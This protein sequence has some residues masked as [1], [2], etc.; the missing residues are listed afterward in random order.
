M[1]LAW[2]GE[3]I[4]FI[5]FGHP[6][7]RAAAT[8]LNDS[9]ELVCDEADIAPPIRKTIERLQRFAAGAPDDFRD[10]EIDLS[11]LGAFQRKVVQACRRIKAGQ[12]RSYG[13]LAAAAGSPRAA[14][15][16]GNV[17]RLNRYP[18]VVPCHRVIGSSGQLGGFSA[19]EGLSMKERL[20]RRE[21]VEVRRTARR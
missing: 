8:S 12:A 17:M 7:A 14:R 2:R 1:G 13:E 5:T 11:H 18:L 20:L 4:T 3:T 15:A 10:V 21:G 6:S 16:V 9:D 19:P